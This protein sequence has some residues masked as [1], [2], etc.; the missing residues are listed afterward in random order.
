[1]LGHTPNPTTIVVPE[2]LIFLLLSKLAS[3][4]TFEV[5]LMKGTTA[6]TD[7]IQDDYPILIHNTVVIRKHNI[8]R[9]LKKI[10]IGLYKEK[11]TAKGLEASLLEKE[12]IG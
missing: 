9:Y 10:S 7:L 5:K 3:E 2:H 12:L 11:N 4:T 1:M 8:L 6:I